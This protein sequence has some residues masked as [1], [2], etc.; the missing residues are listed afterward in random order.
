MD[1][2][3]NGFKSAGGRGSASSSKR[4]GVKKERIRV[5]IADDAV[6]VLDRIGSLL[7]LRYDVVGRALNGRELIEAVGTLLPSVVV[8]DITMPEMDGLE[9]CRLI[10]SKYSGVKVVVISVH[11]DPVIIQASFDAGASAYVWKFAA[12]DELIPAIENVLAGRPY[13]SRGLSAS[14]REE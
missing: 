11:N 14:A 12:H 7:E 4:P 9:A 10:T 6:A 13:L 1:S 3:R 5:V 2:K 8:T